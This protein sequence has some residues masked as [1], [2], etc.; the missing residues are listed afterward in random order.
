MNSLA[1]NSMIGALILLAVIITI[2]SVGYLLDRA[3]LTR[4]ILIALS[5]VIVTLASYAIGTM[6]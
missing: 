4:N 3:V 6:L 1:V 2:V 5:I